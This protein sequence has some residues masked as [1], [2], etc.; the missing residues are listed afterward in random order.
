ME[1]VIL[2]KFIIKHIEKIRYCE[3][4]GKI[5]NTLTEKA[6]TTDYELS[7]NDKDIVSSI[8]GTNIPFDDYLVE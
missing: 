7:R 4:G 8:Y 2:S 1:C 5:D 3:V 6:V